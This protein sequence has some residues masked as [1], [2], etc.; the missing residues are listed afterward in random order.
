MRGKLNV[1]GLEKAI[2][3][4][5]RQHESQRTTFAVKDGNPVQVIAPSFAIALKP[6]DLGSY[7]ETQPEAE[8]RRLGIEEAQQPFDL[9]K[10]P[11]VRARL[12]RLADE[13]HILLLTMHHI[14]SD[15]W[16]AAIALSELCRSTRPSE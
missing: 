13:D 9:A 4:I 2:N 14:V 6:E 15:A 10:G 3:E 8:A 1:P 16:S 12:L 11:L 7:P 5:L